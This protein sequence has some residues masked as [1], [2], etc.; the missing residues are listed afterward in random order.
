ML[1]KLCCR[2]GKIIKYTQKYCEECSKKV[3][4]QKKESYRDY[5]KNRKD[6]KEQ[7][8]YSSFD[9]IN[10]RNKVKRKYKGLCLYSYYVLGEIVYT[11]YIHHIVYLKDEGGWD[12][13]LDINNLV[14]CCASVHEVIHNTK[15]NDKVKMQKLLMELKDRWDREFGK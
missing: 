9:W 1:Y 3:E 15:G 8:F 12:K 5:K 6:K 11:D 4:E 2:C 14:T 13:R 10:V 7:S